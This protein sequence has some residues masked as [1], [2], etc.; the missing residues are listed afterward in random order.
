MTELPEEVPC[1]NCKRPFPEAELD[2]FGWCE[3]CRAVVIR[4]ATRRA[5]IAAT[6]VGLLTA[7][8]VFSLVTADPR[9]L[10]VWIVLIL[11]VA[12]ATFKVAQRVAFEAIRRRGVTPPKS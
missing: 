6:L 4:R 10:I 1:R 3:E 5:W 7:V 8:I 12:F 2:A 9:F 11:A